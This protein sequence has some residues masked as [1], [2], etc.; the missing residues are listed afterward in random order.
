MPGRGDAFVRHDFNDPDG[1]A[2]SFFIAHWK[3]LICH[4]AGVANGK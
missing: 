4:L 3:F 2:Q 1:L